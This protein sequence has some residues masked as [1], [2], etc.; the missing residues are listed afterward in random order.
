MRIYLDICCLNRPFDDQ[1]QARVRLESEAV[2]TI[3]ADISDV[4]FIHS[5]AHDLENS[6]NPHHHRAAR[7]QL[8][9]EEQP[10][11]QISDELLQART[12]E[13]IQMG[14]K[15]FDA[16]HIASAQL[17]NADVFV[18]CDDRLLARANAYDAPS[19]PLR[20]LNPLAFVAEHLP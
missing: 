20:V 18:T 17:A 19:L 6:R 1:R 5:D 16:M 3:M 2:L 13:L 14:F 4:E 9:L 10:L 12:A 7:V 11:V 8:W 15:N